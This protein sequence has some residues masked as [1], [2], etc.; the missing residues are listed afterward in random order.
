MKKRSVLAMLLVLVLCFT[1]GCQKTEKTND[2]DTTEDTTDEQQN[3]EKE[4]IDSKDDEEIVEIVWQLPFLSDFGEG[5]YRV[6]DALNEMLE[7]DIG[8]HITFVRSDL[9]TLQ[10]DAALMVSSGEQLDVCV[11]FGSVKNTVDAGLAIPLDDLYE[12]YGQD[13]LE[14]SA[15]TVERCRID[16]Q[17]YGVSVHDESAGSFGYNMKAEYC[18]KYNL[19]PEE[20][21]IYT[22]DELEAMFEIIDEG[23]EENKLMFV[24]W[25]N[26]YEPLNYNLA[27]YDKMSGDLSWGV[28]MLGEGEDPTKVINLFETEIYADFCQRMYE[29]AQKGWISADAALASEADSLMAADNCVGS[30]AYGEP[31]SRLQQVVSWADD[32][33]VFNT[34]E[35]FT[36][37]GLTGMMWCITPTCEH[38]DKAMQLMNY[39]YANKE[40][41]TLLQYGFEG[42]EYEV[43]ETDGDKKLVRWMDSNPLNLPYYNP[44]PNCVNMTTLPVF[45]PNPIDYYEIRSSLM[46]QAIETPAPS[47]VFDATD[48]AAELSAIQAVIAQYAPSLNAG[49]VDPSVALPD[50]ISA[51]K[52]A[53][54]DKLIDANQEQL[55]AYLAAR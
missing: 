55:D 7:K 35:S 33:Y 31:D 47:Y 39:F 45:E 21:K 49:A 2:A 25:N 22:L 17:L 51:L 34:T 8:V 6:E 28:L 19:Y 40:A 27:E 29:W 20:G 38:P 3:E 18:E 1:A 4:S 13:I 36:V 54:I 53:G 14:Q 12:Q 26:T 46:D 41:A 50:F 44:Y 42:E 9:L 23:E 11:A 16:G 5:V 43:V 24:P 48:Y 32:V 52:D 15:A 10:N 37:G 30:F